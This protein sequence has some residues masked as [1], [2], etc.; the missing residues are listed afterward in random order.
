MK[1]TLLLLAPIALLASCS[2][3]QGQGAAPAAAAANPY[4]IPTN[5]GYNPDAVPYQPVDPINP[6]AMA[7]T[8]VPPTPSYSA[9]APSPAASGGQHM[10]QKG[11]TLWGVSRRYNVSVDALKQA[12][13][14]SGDTIVEGRSL[15]IPGR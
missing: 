12:N 10:I 14:L 9:P 8:P 5:D 1:A 4:G 7:S 11:D 13:G 15:I 6:P 3:N 2:Q